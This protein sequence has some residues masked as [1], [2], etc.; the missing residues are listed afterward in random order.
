MYC[1]KSAHKTYLLEKAYTKRG[2]YFDYLV[3]RDHDTLHKKMGKISR[4]QTKTYPQVQYKISE[5]LNIK[6][7][8]EY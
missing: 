6:S 5:F 4:H 2:E 7:K 3:D 8:K 1:C